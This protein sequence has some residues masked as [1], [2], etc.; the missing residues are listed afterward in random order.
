MARD[1]YRITP[2][3]DGDWKLKRD[4]ASRAASIQEAIQEA[5]H[6]QHIHGATYMVS[7]LTDRKDLI[8]SLAL[9]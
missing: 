4:G 2:T 3:G 8:I 1:K 5:I 9:N 6:I 7:G